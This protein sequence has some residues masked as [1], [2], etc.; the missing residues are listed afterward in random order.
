MSATH[1]PRII[2]AGNKLGWEWMGHGNNNSIM[3]GNRAKTKNA[4]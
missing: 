2:E 3:L 1:Y 4:R